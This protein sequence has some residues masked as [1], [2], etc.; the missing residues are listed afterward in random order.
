MDKPCIF[1]ISLSEKY[2]LP[3]QYFKKNVLKVRNFLEKDFLYSASDPR[4]KKQASASELFLET[5]GQFIE[6]EYGNGNGNQIN[7]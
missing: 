3:R 7:R 2:I 4:Y 5:M 6:Q 1:L